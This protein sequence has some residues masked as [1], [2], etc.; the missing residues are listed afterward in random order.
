MGPS[1]P[2]CLNPLLSP[3][4]GGRHGCLRV[5][6]RVL[7][8]LRGRDSKGPPPSPRTHGG[9]DQ[10]FAAASPGG[11]VGNT[12]YLGGS[13]DPSLKDHLSPL[14]CRGWA[15]LGP[16]G[17]LRKRDLELAAPIAVAPL[18]PLPPSSSQGRGGPSKGAQQ[19]QSPLCA[20]GCCAGTG[21]ASERRGGAV[22][23][24]PRLHQGEAPGSGWSGGSPTWASPASRW[25]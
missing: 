24:P 2:S 19:S 18:L 1:Q 11:E 10:E 6:G 16:W 9:W 4:A 25:S 23:T 7:G 12:T 3:G 20:L 14:P 13:A 8:P 21:G 17:P 22:R 5:I 15:A